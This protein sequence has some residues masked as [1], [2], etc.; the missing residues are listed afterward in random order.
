[1]AIIKF[2]NSYDLIH[3]LCKQEVLGEVAIEYSQL[4]STM[5]E[6]SR[7]N[8][9]Y[10]ALEK[11]LDNIAWDIIEYSG[12]IA[13]SIQVKF[14]DDKQDYNY[15]IEGTEDDFDSIDEDFQNLLQS[16]LGPDAFAIITL[17]GSDYNL[18]SSQIRR[19]KFF[20]PTPDGEKILNLAQEEE[21]KIL[22]GIFSILQGKDS[23]IECLEEFEFRVDADTVNLIE[24][25]ALIANNVLSLKD[26]A[27]FELDTDQLKKR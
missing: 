4:T 22:L 18:E 7:F 12:A 3:Y 8:F 21:K 19:W 2:D 6:A 26:D 16:V 27:S 24:K 9:S 20:K 25:G 5:L 10:P 11:H 13:S 23:V 17:E 15:T 1:M 14:Y